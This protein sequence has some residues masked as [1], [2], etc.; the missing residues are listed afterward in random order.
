MLYTVGCKLVMHCTIH[1]F[2]KSHC[3]PFGG[4]TYDSW[5]LSLFL[6]RRHNRVLVGYMVDHNQ[7]L[8]V[9]PLV[10]QPFSSVIPM[11]SLGYPFYIRLSGHAPSLLL[12]TPKSV[13]ELRP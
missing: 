9:V 8:I 2:V 10:N 5:L 1:Y 4:W 11:I 6:L 7:D 12:D 13:D 3:G